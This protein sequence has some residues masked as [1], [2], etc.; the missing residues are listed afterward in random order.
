[1]IEHNRVS[2]F[3]DCD[4]ASCDFDYDG[5]GSIGTGTFRGRV[6]RREAA[7]DRRR[8]S[9]PSGALPHRSGGPAG[10]ASAVDGRTPGPGA[11]SGW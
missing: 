10:I 8:E 11:R 3:R 1:M 4:E 2:G 9:G 7:R 6:A 5:F